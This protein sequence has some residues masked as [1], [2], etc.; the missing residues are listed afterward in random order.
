MIPAET[1]TAAREKSILDVAKLCGAALKKT[2]SEWNG[3]CPACGGADRFWLNEAEN[4]FLCRASGHAGDPIALIRH[5]HG[6]GF[7]EAVEMLTGARA[8]PIAQRP[9]ERSTEQENEY[10]RKAQIR[11]HK[12]WQNGY[13]AD[14]AKG[15]H[16]VRDYFS[17]RGIPFPSWR[18]RTLREADRL[19]YWTFDKEAN[20][21]IHIYTGP[22]MLA[23]ITGPDGKF[24]GVHR[25]WLDLKHSS[26]KARIVHPKTG[27]LLPA[28]KVEGSQRGGKIVLRDGEPGGVC[29]LGEGIETVLSWPFLHPGFDAASLWSGINL[30][31]ICGKAAEKIPHP[32]LTSKDSL[33]RERRVK[34]G[35]TE[36]D[37][38][39]EHCLQIPADDFSRL[40][41]P[42]DSDSD[43]F[44]TQAAMVRA[45]TRF[46]L[47]GHDA[48][49]DWA[50]DGQDWNDALRGQVR[51]REGVAA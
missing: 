23:A 11:A 5:K 16:L 45:R 2:G 20:E 47:T 25:T 51:R 1:V 35:G 27:E 39:D 15:D 41:L 29:V 7:S 22:A 31:N 48:E 4:V 38:S 36:P 26:G 34:V 43:R 33:G 8:T 37:L 42:G 49:I 40:I 6:V 17:L 28:K 19:P 44:T 32:S 18:I 46:E 10:R 50:P 24:I 12:I 13:N 3:P 14:P 9:P 30:D 21:Y